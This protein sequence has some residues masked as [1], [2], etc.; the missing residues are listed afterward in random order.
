MDN[1][2]KGGLGEYLLMNH[3]L[4]PRYASVIGA[5]MYECGLVNFRGKGKIDLKK[6][7]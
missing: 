5:I 3:G 2:I 6:I 7:V 1:P 4:S